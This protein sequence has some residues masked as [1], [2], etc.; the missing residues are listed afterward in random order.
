[1][2]T[3]LKPP[4]WNLREAADFYQVSER[5]MWSLA[6][7]G[8]VPGYRIGKQWRFDPEA[9]AEWSA[10]AGQANVSIANSHQANS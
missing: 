7:Q 2:T 9:L 10:A 8:K 5:L 1:M 3:P 6:T 4:Q